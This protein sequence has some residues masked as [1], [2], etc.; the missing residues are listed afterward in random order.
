ML[1]KGS[2]LLVIGCFG[3]TYTLASNDR[4]PHRRGN[5]LFVLGK[6]VVFLCSHENCDVD[7]LI[8]GLANLS[9]VGR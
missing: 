2:H 3:S 7:P 9:A 8:T 1:G 4:M 5:S 6:I